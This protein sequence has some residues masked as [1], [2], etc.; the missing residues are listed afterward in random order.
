M[1][2]MKLKS[3][4]LSVVMALS[5]IV[6]MMS[7]ISMTSKAVEPDLYLGDETIY[8]TS[9]G[10]NWAYDQSSKTLTLT[11]YSYSG[12]APERDGY[13]ATIYAKVDLTIVL[14]G[15]NNITNTQDDQTAAYVIKCANDVNSL[16]IKGNGTLNATG[17]MGMFTGQ[18]GSIS[19]E[20]S[21]V[22]ITTNGNKVASGIRTWR[23]AVTIKDNSKV[24]INVTD[25]SQ[26]RAYGIESYRDLLVQD[27]IVKVIN[28]N[29][30]GLGSTTNITFKNS[31]IEAISSGTDITNIAIERASETDGTIRFI[32]SNV[33]AR[34]A[35]AIEFSK[36]TDGELHIEGGTLEAIGTTSAIGANTTVYSDI[37]G[38]RW[39][40]AD[41]T[42]TKENFDASST[43][44]SLSNYKKVQFPSIA[45]AS[46]T[47]P[48]AINPSYTGMAQALVNAG[49]SNEGTLQYA[50]GTDSSNPPETGWSTSVPSATDKGT[51]YVWYKVIGDNDHFD[52]DPAC[53]TV[54][55]KETSPTPN[56]NPNSGNDG[57][58]SGD[59][60][61]STQTTSTTKA[62]TAPKTGDV[63]KVML[64]VLVIMFAMSATFVIVRR[65]SKQK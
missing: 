41:G 42:G 4:I 9:S 46:A 27:S 33:I 10:P 26:E 65:K 21:T 57:T 49:F 54:T 31:N 53:V 50:L 36:K 32:G 62:K 3:K 15:E 58:V 51:Y 22:N 20:G 5:L 48:T 34:G 37:G 45:K 17:R 38:T 29:G 19:I 40:N 8:G 64:P 43:G 2:R 35:K 63:A 25:S 1:L 59:T 7:G 23:G 12:A 13:Y 61:D 6:G 55:I 14:V 18:K 28:N 16:T 44:Q 30:Y 24:S 47:A 11:N 56:Q 39:L 60:T 52:S